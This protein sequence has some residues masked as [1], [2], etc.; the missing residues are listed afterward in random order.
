MSYRVGIFGA[1]GA[2]GQELLRLLIERNFPADSIRLFASARSAGKTTRFGERTWTIEEATVDAFDELDLVLMSISGSFSE[3]MSPE[4]VKRGCVVVDNSS[5]FRMTA[6]VPLVI[7]EINAHTLR[8][9]QGIIANP[10]CSTAVTLMGLYPLHQ[11]FTVRRIIASTYQAVSGS[12]VGGMIELENQLRAWNEGKEPVVATYPYPIAFNVIPQVDVFYPDGY[13]KEELKMANESR[14]IMAHGD[15]AVSTT[16]VRVP[17]MRAHSV[18][19][20]AEF[21]QPVDL[22]EAREAIRNFPGVKLVDDPGN[23]MYPMPR[24]IA[25]TDDCAVGRL[26]LDHAFENGLAFWIVGDQLLKGAA[27]NTVQIAEALHKAALVRV[28]PNA[29]PVEV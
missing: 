21:E 22:E 1:T 14:K 5:A 16:C 17:V 11:R 27:L 15:L 23:R 29:Q 8:E 3:K 18:S 4:A 2:V 24:D 20:S 12:G 6:G 13:T 9:H 28:P 25:G 7:P 26:R 19:V 10:N